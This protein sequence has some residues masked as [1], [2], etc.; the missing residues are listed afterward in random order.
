MAL[1]EEQRCVVIGSS[2]G[3]VAAILQIVASLPPAFPCP[4]LIVQHIGA[5]QSRLAEL[6]SKA[7][8]NPAAFP[9]NGDSPIDGVIYI[10]PPDR[11]ML[12]DEGRIILSGGPKENLARP[13]IDPLFRSAALAYE[14]RCV[15]VILT[16]L[17]DDGSAGLAA[18]KACGGVTIVQDPADAEQREMPESAI[19]GTNVDYILGLSEI[20]AT[21]A[22]II[23]Q[24]LVKFKGSPPAYLRREHAARDG[25]TLVAAN[26]AIGAPSALTCP[27]C[28][29][30]LFKM[31]GPGATRYRCHTGHAYSI[32]S[33]AHASAELTEQSIWAAVK[34]LHEKQAILRAMAESGGPESGMEKAILLQE[35]ERCANA[36]SQLARLARGN[37]P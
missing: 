20:G 19:A 12:I 11:H 33:L 24:P 34:A 7:G 25:G 2:M 9:T 29:G 13:A 26:N 17:M 3:G 27:D 16:G 23:R 14:E 8:P 4:I 37:T 36:S 21:L 1:H 10:A 22:K 31:D 18:V 6:V 32:R 30:A 5:H 15:G 28:G 35:L